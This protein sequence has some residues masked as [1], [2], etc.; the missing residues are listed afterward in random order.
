MSRM[1]QL[2]VAV[3]EINHASGELIILS[4]IVAKLQLALE[5]VKAL[6]HLKIV[7]SENQPAIN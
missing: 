6:L 4:N 2:I 1:N 3:D 7:N 5:V